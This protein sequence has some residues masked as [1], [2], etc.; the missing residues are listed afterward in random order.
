[1]YLCAKFDCLPSEYV[2]GILRQ[3]VYYII[4]YHSKRIFLNNILAYLWH[5]DSVAYKDMPVCIVELYS[6]GIMH[7]ISRD[8]FL[9]GSLL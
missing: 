7:N 9:V 1:M 8:V 5:Y 3:A 2:G 6:F 4:V